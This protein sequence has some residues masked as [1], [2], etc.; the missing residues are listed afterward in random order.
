[1]LLADVLVQCR[2]F[3]DDAWT[4]LGE[5]RVRLQQD[6]LSLEVHDPQGPY[7]IDMTFERIHIEIEEASTGPILFIKLVM[8]DLTVVVEVRGGHSQV[9]AL[10]EAVLSIE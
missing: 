1:M 6:S 7:C 10:A 9:T 5:C 4:S 3:R 2:L 8:R